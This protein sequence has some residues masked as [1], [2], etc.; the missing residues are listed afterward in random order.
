LEIRIPFLDSVRPAPE[1]LAKL[2]A[3]D[4][5]GGFPQGLPAARWPA[6]ESCGEPMT[7]VAQIRHDEAYLDLGATGRTVMI[8]QCDKGTC[9]SW[10][11]LSGANHCLVIEGD[12]LGDEETM[13]PPDASD[14]Y[15]EVW[16]LGWMASQEDISPEQLPAFFSYDDWLDLDEDV[17]ANVAHLTK[18]GGAPSWIQKPETP[19][20]SWCF[21]GQI[22]FL[23]AFTSPPTAPKDW[24]ELVDDSEGALFTHRAFGPNFGDNGMMYLFS[25]SEGA[26]TKV[27]AL[28]QC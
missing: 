10:L 3:C 25:R 4:K 27:A 17:T 16:V 12:D 22:G 14:P 18:L 15:H 7:F 6:C 28:W 23:Y 21:I 11:P 1:T 24:I 26:E 13:P 9:E 19:G 5:F 2:P 20:E 8:F